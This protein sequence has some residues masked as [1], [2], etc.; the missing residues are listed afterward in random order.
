MLL[1]MDLMLMPSASVIISW[2]RLSVTTAGGAG[3]GVFLHIKKQRHNKTIQNPKKNTSF[4]FRFS[5]YQAH[6]FH[7]GGG[8]IGRNPFCKYPTIL[9]FA[10]CITTVYSV[11]SF[12]IG[13]VFMILY[14][15]SSVA[16]SCWPSCCNKPLP[17]I[18]RGSG[19]GIHKSLLVWMNPQFVSFSATIGRRVVFKDDCRAIETPW[20]RCVPATTKY[21][22]AIA[23]YVLKR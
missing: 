16:A 17:T 21:W 22:G 2:P 15:E 23:G 1:Q 8:G 10:G 20:Y 4:Y 6:S 3:G 19:S 18:R 14:T 12:L 9:L 5:E 13:Q 7:E 11:W